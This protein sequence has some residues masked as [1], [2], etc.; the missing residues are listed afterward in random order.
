[1]MLAKSRWFGAC[2]V[3]VALLVAGCS[4][5][6]PVDVAAKRGPC[7]NPY[8]TV[9]RRFSLKAVNEGVHGLGASLVPFPAQQVRV[10]SY[11]SG[12]RTLTG[13]AV[14][15][16]AVAA[17]FEAS[18]N[19]LQTGTTQPAGLTCHQFDTS[20]LTFT[21]ATEGMAVAVA[22][23][24]SG[25]ASNGTLTL[26]STRAWLNELTAYTARQSKRG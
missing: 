21:T 13:T 23:C 14:L 18:T 12:G 10:C 3:S 16:Q 2:V 22:D 26:A 4:H 17:Q 15:K 24:G 19:R 8:P 25:V 6:G 11:D 7:P 20:L 9:S 1:M 5:A